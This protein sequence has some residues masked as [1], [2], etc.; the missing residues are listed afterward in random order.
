MIASLLLAILPSTNAESRSWK[1]IEWAELIVDHAVSSLGYEV[2][3]KF[4]VDDGFEP[5]MFHRSGPPPP[6]KDLFAKRIESRPWF[7]GRT[8]SVTKV[9]LLEGEIDVHVE[10]VNAH[11]I[12]QIGQ[13]KIIIYDNGAPNN[14]WYIN[15]LEA[16]LNKQFRLFSTTLEIQ[17]KKKQ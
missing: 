15:E 17:R 1:K 2:A 3:E 10:C 16:H 5:F 13:P 14:D 8:S 7:F 6:Y 11:S 9:L 12:V 4:G